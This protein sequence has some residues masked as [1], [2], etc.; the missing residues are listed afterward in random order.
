MWS[1]L[2][3]DILYLNVSV[4]TETF[5]SW[6]S[7]W[8]R[9]QEREQCQLL[10]CLIT[11]RR[12]NFASGLSHTT[13][14]H[15][16]DG[17]PCVSCKTKVVWIC[18]RVSFVFLLLTCNSRIQY[19]FQVQVW[20]SW[21][22]WMTSGIAHTIYAHLIINFPINQLSQTAVFSEAATNFHIISVCKPKPIEFDSYYSE[23]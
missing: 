13:S 4:A 2:S 9:E 5:H 19:N 6:L 23:K 1:I 10:L 18:A 16:Q 15:N 14:G 17:W 8:C 22:Q 7:S 21:L 3:K 12:W 11:D 20:L